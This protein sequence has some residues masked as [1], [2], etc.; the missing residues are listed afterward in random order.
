MAIADP[1]LRRRAIDPLD[2]DLLAALQEWN[3]RLS[4]APPTPSLRA[5]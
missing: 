4:T 1:T 5:V 2:T 3:E